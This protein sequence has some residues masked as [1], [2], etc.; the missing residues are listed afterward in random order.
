MR[1]VVTLKTDLSELNSSNDDYCCYYDDAI[2]VDEP[3][4]YMNGCVTTAACELGL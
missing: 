1:S 4:V 3:A 2:V